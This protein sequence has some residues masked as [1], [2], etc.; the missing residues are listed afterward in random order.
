MKKILNIVTSPGKGASATVQLSDGII[1][2]LLGEYP[3]STVTTR[4]LSEN[5]LPHLDGLLLSSFFSPAESHNELQQAAIRLSDEAIAQVREADIIVLG[6]PMYNFGIP[7]TLK[8]WL[9]H[10]FRAGVT[11]SYGPDG[12]KGLLGDKKIYLSIASGGVYS[13]G[14]MSD[15]DFTDPYLRKA[16]GFI[17]LTDIT[18]FR[19]E[20]LKMA[21]GDQV[22]E[23]VVDSMV[24]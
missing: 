8:A 15:Y 4:D 2:K 5:P 18:T 22:V 6:V 23:N 17:G 14:P 9:D 20:G 12:P 11:F 1:E 24:I 10:I 19:A 13:E 3:G 16:L 7:S 21:G